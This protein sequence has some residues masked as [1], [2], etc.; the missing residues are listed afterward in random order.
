M[1]ISPIS[2]RSWRWR[3][4]ALVGIAAGLLLLC[5]PSGNTVAQE[6]TPAATSPTPGQAGPAQTPEESTEAP[7]KSEAPK[8]PPAPAAEEKP[9]PTENTAK[10]ELT[11][12]SCYDCHNPDILKLSKD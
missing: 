8:P 2:F 7:A 10:Q 3:A 12:Q 9:K 4:F 5:G 6:Q 1:K 11:N